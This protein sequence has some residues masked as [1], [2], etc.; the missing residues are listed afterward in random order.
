MAEFI[1]TIDVL[2]DGAVIDSI[3]GRTIAEFKDDRIE[4]VRDYAFYNCSNLTEVDLPSAT[5]VKYSAFTGCSALTKVNIPAVKAIEPYNAFSNCRSIKEIV[6]PVC[7]KIGNGAFSFCTGLEKVDCKAT[8]SIEIGNSAFGSTTALKALIIRSNSVATML[9]TNALYESGIFFGK[10]YIYV[11][12]ALIDSYKAATNWSTFANQFR[13]LEE[14]TVDGTVT[15][16]INLNQHMVRFFDE[17]GTFLGYKVVAAGGTA[18]YDGTPVKGDD[19]EFIGW[20]PEP[21]NVTADMDC[22]AQFKSTAMTWTEVFG[23]IADGTY[24]G[25]LSIGDTVPLDLG[26]EG[27]VNMQIIAFDTDDLAD[28]S[29]KAPITWLSKELLASNRQMNP[30]RSGGTTGTGGIGGWENCSMRTYLSGTL[31]PNIPELVRNAIKEVSKTH[32]SSNMYGAL[33]TQTTTDAV[34][35]PS[36]DEMY[37][38]SSLYFGMFQDTSSLRI[39]MKSGDTTGAYWYLRDSAN[40]N[41]FQCVAVSGSIITAY[42]YTKYGV[43]LGFCT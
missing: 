12:S 40:S 16:E 41:S 36:Q 13:K 18:T 26:D 31:K 39:K 25:N 5:S 4:T 21:I 27:V 38:E 34:W 23:Y 14:W 35:I 1:N 24:K 37:G 17:D 29:G 9:S 20:K 42:A 2:G 28:G 22:Y 15:G 11:P 30:E 3:I 32:Q 6:L 43:A 19:Y 33:A 10:G 8:G 7:T